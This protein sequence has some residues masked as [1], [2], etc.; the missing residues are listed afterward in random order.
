MHHIYILYLVP[1]PL[2]R[3]MRN[4]STKFRKLT[5]RERA[6]ERERETAPQKGV[7]DRSTKGSL[8]KKEL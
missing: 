5:D 1:R 6:R 7:L 3:F 8:A 4:D 2:L